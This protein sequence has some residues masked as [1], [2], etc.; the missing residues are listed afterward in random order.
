[1]TTTFQINIDVTIGATAELTQLL[2]ALLPGRDLAFKACDTRGCTD[3]TPI[4]ADKLAPT[5][6]KFFSEEAQPAD[7][8]ATSADNVETSAANVATPAEEEPAPAVT[9]AEKIYTEVDVREAMDRTRRRIEGEDYKTN[10]DG[11]LYKKWHRKLTGW[12]KNTAAIY[13]SDKPS[14][15]PDSDSRRK[16]IEDCD[17]VHPNEDD[18][19]MPIPF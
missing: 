12:F 10:T 9:P 2:T 13:G 1:M 8:V 7:S 6:I 3:R 14:T 16:F 4:A 5:V 19:T 18:L 15:L 17:R 11:E